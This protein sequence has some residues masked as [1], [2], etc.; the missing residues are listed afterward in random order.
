MMSSLDGKQEVPLLHFKTDL[1]G[2][3][4]VVHTP[5]AGGE[6]RIREFVGRSSKTDAMD[7]ADRVKPKH[8]S[9]L[10]LHREGLP[11]RASAERASVQVHDGVALAFNQG[12]PYRQAVVEPP[13]IEA[14][15]VDVRCPS[16]LHAPRQGLAEVGPVLVV[17]QD[18]RVAF[19]SACRHGIQ[20]AQDDVHLHAEV[21]RMLEP[22][23][24]RDHLIGVRS[25][26]FGHAVQW[27]VASSQQQHAEGHVSGWKAC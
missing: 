21:R 6:H 3:G 10:H 14:D 25:E 16:M 24:D 18:A 22:S 8:G 2:R 11:W 17:Q 23:I 19:K 5:C 13:T 26:A 27:Q 7:H 15:H 1:R 12:S 4:N 9:W 20:V